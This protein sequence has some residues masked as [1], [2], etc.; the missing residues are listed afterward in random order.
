[1]GGSVTHKLREAD[2]SG[3]SFEIC[4]LSRPYDLWMPLLGD[5]Q[6]EN[7]ATALATLE[8]LQTRGYDIS[9]DSIS[10]GFKDVSW[11]AR[12]QRLSHDG[13]EVLVDGAHN[14][15]SMNRLVGTIGEFYPSK[16]A[17]VVFGALSGHSAKGMLEE[18]AV[19][20]PDLVCVRSRHPRSAPSHIIRDIA[21]KLGMNVVFETENVGEGTR[22]A[23]ELSRED[24]F[25]LGTGSL[26]V[27]AEIIEEIR[28][29]SPELYPNIKPPT[30]TA[31]RTN[32]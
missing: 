18:L 2:A 23:V 6:L 22:K 12:F 11:P 5:I 19:L 13:I 21:L 3:Q 15:Y 8:E 26:S 1:M 10:K 30:M 32:A 9:W 20:S 25:I 14:P 16:S 4:G 24:D 28:G 7:A 31:T 27:A 29:M 17:I